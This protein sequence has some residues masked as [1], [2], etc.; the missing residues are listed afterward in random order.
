MYNNEIYGYLCSAVGAKPRTVPYDVFKINPQAFCVV[1]F[2]TR[3]T[4]NPVYFV[5]VHLELYAYAQDHFPQ[6]CRISYNH[7]PLT[8]SILSGLQVLLR[9]A[10]NIPVRWAGELSVCWTGD[11]QHQCSFAPENFPET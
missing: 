11:C 6:Y 9:W 1:P 2:L 4:A 5:S 3:L 7:C 8:P 10:E